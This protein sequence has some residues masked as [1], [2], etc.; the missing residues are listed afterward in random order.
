MSILGKMF[1]W[2]GR[3][4]V[5]IFT[6]VRDAVNSDAMKDLVKSALGDIA[7]AAISKASQ[8]DGD[9]FDKFKAAFIEAKLSAKAEGLE[10]K[11]SA[12]SLVIQAIIAGAKHS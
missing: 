8:V 10:F 4:V 6:A 5:N 3:R 11:D 12:L 1:G 9:D 2:I 7:R